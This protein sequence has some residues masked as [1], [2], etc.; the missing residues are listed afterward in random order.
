MKS[1]TKIQVRFHD[2]D[3]AGHVHNGIYLSYFEQGRLDFFKQLAGENWDWKKH[4]LILGRNE[5][6]YIKPV[7]LHYEIFVRTVCD[8]VG[9]KSFALSYELYR[10]IN[11]EEVIYTKGRSILVCI[12]Y[13]TEQTVPVYPEWRDK[14]AG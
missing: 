3:M 9:T 4:G 10:E 11:G 13:H 5:I 1:V 8:H 12:D 2:I 6:D 14:L 7:K